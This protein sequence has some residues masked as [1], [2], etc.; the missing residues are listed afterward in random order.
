MRVIAIG[1]AVTLLFSGG[2]WRAVR[3]AI[4][5]DDPSIPSREARINLRVS[6]ADRVADGDVFDL[7]APPGFTSFGADRIINTSVG[8]ASARSGIST[9]TTFKLADDTLT[10]QSR[11]SFDTTASNAAGTD[12]FGSGSFSF[13]LPIKITERPYEYSFS[14][15]VDYAIR[16]EEGFGDGAGAILS[17]FG[18]GRQLLNVRESHGNESRSGSV[19]FSGSGTLG[20]GFSLFGVILATNATGNGGF[21]GRNDADLSANFQL[22]I[23]PASRWIEPVNG[24]YQVAGHWTA[25]TVPG[26]QDVAIF[27]LPGTYTVTLA[28][29]AANKRLRASGNG[30]NV[31]LDLA[32]NRY[33][34]DELHLGDPSGNFSFTLSDS[35]GIVVAAPGDK[36]PWPAPG[37]G[38]LIA[39]LLQWDNPGRTDITA[40][41]TTP[42]G[43]ID[44]GHTVNVQGDGHWEV[45]SLS[46]GDAV[47]GT[48]N[49]SGGGK[50]ESKFTTIGR[51]ER[52][53]SGPGKV[54]V[55]NIAGTGG[56]VSTFKASR[57]LTVG[58][59]GEGVLEIH[60]RGE[61]RAESITVG[62]DLNGIGVVTVDGPSARLTQFSI[63]R[64]LTIGAQGKGVL[65]VK[66]GPPVSLD[67]QD[68]QVDVAGPFEIGTGAGGISDGTVNVTNLGFINAQSLLKV[69]GSGKGAMSVTDHGLV[70][71]DRVEIGPKGKVTL[72]DLGVLFVDT[73]LTVNGELLVNTTG[74]AIVSNAGF[75][76]TLGKLTIGP[77]GT[78]KGSGKI[79]AD[80]NLAGGTSEFPFSSILAPANSTGTLT[81]EGDVV[82][83][84]GSVIEIEIAGTAAGQ[85]DVLAVTGDI[86]LGGDVFLEFT[87]GFAPHQGD[88]FEF[89]DVSGAQAG[90]FANV[91]LRNLAPGFQFDLRRDGGAMTMV[92]LNDGVFMLPPS[93][94]WNVDGNGNW[95]S[96][97]NWTVGDP[98]HAGATAVFG[99]KITAPRSVTTDEPITVGRIDFD[100][101]NAYTIDGDDT[102]TLNAT[103]G[104]A[105]INVTSGSHTIS[106]PLTLADDTVITVSPAAG[107]LSITGALSASAVKLTKV[108]AGTLTLNNLRAAG[109]S[110]DAGTL[111]M[112]PS[113]TAAGTSLVGAL[114]IAGGATPTA[115]LDLNNNAAIINYTG[116]SPAATVRQQL[117]AGRGGPGLGAAWNGQGITS[118][119]AAAA[120][121]TDA[122]SRSV[123]YAENS[124]LPLGPYTTFRGQ[125][126]DDTALLMA[127]TRTGDANLDGLVNDDDVTIVGATYAPGVSQ[128]SWA[129]GDFDYNGFVDDDDVTLLGVF[130]NPSAPPLIEPAPNES[131]GIAAVPEPASIVLL[132][133]GLTA[134]VVAYGSAKRRHSDRGSQQ[135]S[136]R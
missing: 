119:A 102:V 126:V 61:V 75:G 121:T 70:S 52:I 49:V 97:S 84:P 111:A 50:V 105:Q 9:N 134:L 57:Q 19:P 89:L 112:A 48:L 20:I 125:P 100:N 96:V 74:G 45:N 86:T 88:A 11:T 12:A 62:V 113:G 92:A 39:S 7:N 131:S 72:A 15:Q 41:T 95:T 24:T 94:A 18:G 25:N 60:N 26:A 107:N 42:T 77:G 29:N 68:A 120:N 114:S 78:L 55:G 51:E 30:T 104:A 59:D 44:K 87:D 58:F 122:E 64:T 136:R 56:L 81:I 37:I 38:E 69:G 118:S 117:L 16:S 4:I 106:A 6:A 109:L 85:F 13:S 22:N 27:D 47:S 43:L 14:G 67:P 103:S 5:I 124:A 76:V 46:V 17:F 127:F 53:L 34:L 135:D 40:K 110:I 82:Q 123:G 54:V 83:E 31:T 79:F 99:G 80:L 3:A 108:G 73:V 32:G 91:E 90:S 1:T 2:N 65:N 98:N 115:K 130:Y 116:T 35:S 28:G 8:G 36:G 21:P 71:A 10:V 33:K 133:G 63:D 129:L 66:N 128:P 93:S 101:A 132:V 23:S